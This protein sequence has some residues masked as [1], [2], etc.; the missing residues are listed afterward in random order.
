MIGFDSVAVASE[1]SLLPDEIPVL[2]GCDWS[3]GYQ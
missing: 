2:F 3:G 1:F